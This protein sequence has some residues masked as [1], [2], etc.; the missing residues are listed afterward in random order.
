MHEFFWFWAYAQVKCSMLGVT[1]PLKLSVLVSLQ[2]L[3]VSAA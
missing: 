2:L 3:E 1:A